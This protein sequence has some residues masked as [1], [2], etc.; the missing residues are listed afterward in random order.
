[1]GLFSILGVGTSGLTAAQM[2][3]EVAGQNIANV[4]VEGYSRKRLNTVSAFRRDGHFGQ[5]GFGV[6]I[7]NIER[8]RDAYTDEQIRKQT[9]ESGYFE[10]IDEALQRIENVFLEPGDTGILSYID[11]FFD[12][13]NNLANNPSDEAARTVVQTTGQTLSDAFHNLNG[14]LRALQDSRN[15]EI[16]ALVQRVNEIS[17]EI[18]NLN[19]EIS[20]VEIGTQN[21]NDSRDQRDQL[22][23]ELSKIIDVEVIE[24]DLG[25]IS[26]TTMGNIIVS[27]VGTQKL[28]LTT[29]Q[30]QR[31]DGTTGNNVGI[32]FEESKSPYYPMSGQMK[33]LIDT[34][35]T[36]IPYY[37]QQLDA[38]AVAI[39]GRINEVHETG[40]SL[41]GFS[42]ISFFDPSV[43]G[44]SDI[45]VSAAVKQN[46]RN[47]A[48]AKGGETL[49]ATQNISHV[50][51]TAA[52]DLTYRSL[53]QNSVTVTDTASGTVLQEGV[54]YNIDYA[55]GSFQ[56]LN[57]TF[58]GSALV[59][60]Y[61]YN[62]GGFAGEGNNENAISI[63]QLRYSLTMIP[64][65]LGNST[66][67]FEQFYGAF[68]AK[69]GLDRNEAQST[70]ETRNFL[71]EQYETEQD[72]VA[73]VSLDE[74]MADLIKFQHTYQAS[75]RL[76]STA[77]QMLEVLMNI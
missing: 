33:G 8:L 51:G 20:A 68:V 10:K 3:M 24:N 13:W 61:Q 43:T 54:D 36:V 29:T 21:A 32:R 49:G 41:D 27:P 47:I 16:S 31:A 75:A 65:S 42:G 63:A 73:G 19:R 26:V 11:N 17:E 34:R 55:R 62:S 15:N 2:G 14:E 37:E 69:L 1:M 44:A 6:E 74:E 28:E 18:S 25:Q 72:S 50:F 35:D 39:V 58:S 7:I 22:L 40:Y 77:N 76:I 38:L 70:L 23:K 57:S 64:D 45:S 67:T 48:A 60:D 71:V 56:L 30:F 66:A 5:M 9:H 4:D 12:S 59:I 52:M 46:I 53:L